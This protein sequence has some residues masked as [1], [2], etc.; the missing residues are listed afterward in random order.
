MD[1]HQALRPVGLGFLCRGLGVVLP[2]RGRK[3]G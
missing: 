3:A 1:N 2:A